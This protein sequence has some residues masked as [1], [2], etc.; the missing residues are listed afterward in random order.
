MRFTHT[1][2]KGSRYNQIYVPKSMQ[3]EFELGDIVEVILIEKKNKLFYSPHIKR[4]SNFKDRLIR[5][6]FSFLSKFKEIEQVFVFGSFLTTQI[7]YHD[8]DLLIFLKKESEELDKK[9]LD[10]LIGEFN[11]KFHILSATREGFL[12]VLEYSP[13]ERSM[14]YYFVSNKEFKVPSKREI[15]EDNIRSLLM[16][17]EDIFKVRFDEGRVFYDSLRKLITIESFLR[18]KDIAPETIDKEIISLLNEKKLKILKEN[19][20]VNNELFREL[21]GIFKAKVER[22]HEMLHGKK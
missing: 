20:Y 12:K 15:H 9:I 11:L 13:I 4:L 19:E 17:P 18:G 5:E 7:E 6:I 10:S 22:I 8:I 14:M 2:S 1:V 16:M 21:K 3:K